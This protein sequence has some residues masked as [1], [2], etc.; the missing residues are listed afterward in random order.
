[1]S[2]LQFGRQFGRTDRGSSDRWHLCSLSVSGGGINC[3]PVDAACRA[4]KKFLATSPGPCS[5]WRDQ[6]DPKVFAVC[7]GTYRKDS[8]QVLDSQHRGTVQ[9]ASRVVRD[10]Q[11]SI[12]L[13]I[14]C[15]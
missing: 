3:K 15:S 12:Y 2:T 4:Q 9:R 7:A 14:R 8:A 5:L 1:M 10:T 11:L 13:S 6:K